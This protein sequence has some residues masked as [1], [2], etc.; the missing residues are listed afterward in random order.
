LTAGDYDV[1]VQDAAGCEFDQVIT[2]S[3]AEDLIIELGDDQVIAFGDSLMLSPQ[4]NFDI[5]VV[6][7][8]DS[9]LMGATPFVKPINTTS[10]EIT[11]FD[12]DGCV[13]TDFIT[14][15]V[16]KTRPVYIP[17]GFSPNGDGINDFF[18]VYVDQD[19]ITNVKNFNVYDRWGETMYARE[20]LTIEQILNETNG[21]DGKHRTQDMNPGVYVYHLLVEFIDG[22]EILYEGNITLM[23]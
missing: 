7:W 12:D 13:T 4:T 19:L 8:N 5:D 9:L 2:I 1:L 15:F 17:S 22:E 3:P 6:E 21:W 10:Y 20:D 18:T 16:E 23:R 14:I 11:A